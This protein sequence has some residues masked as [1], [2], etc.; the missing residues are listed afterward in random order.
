[1][2]GSNRLYRRRRGQGMTEYVVL[3]GLIAIVIAVAVFL[4]RDKIIGVFTSSGDQLEAMSTGVDGQDQTGY[5][6]TGSAP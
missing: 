4:F 3:V 5:E 1:M 2:K 6:S